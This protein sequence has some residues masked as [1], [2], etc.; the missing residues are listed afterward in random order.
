MNIKIK[1]LHLAYGSKVLIEEFNI[2]VSSGERVAIMG[3]NGAGKSTL[4]KYINKHYNCIY[5]PQFIDCDGSGGEKFMRSFN[6]AQKILRCEDSVALLLDEPTNHLDTRNRRHLFR[7]L[8]R[9]DG[10]LICISHDIELLEMFSNFWHIENESVHV[11]RGNYSDYIKERDK[12]SKKM[13]DDKEGLRKEKE[14]IS[15]LY[16]KIQERSQGSGAQRLVKEINLKRIL[17]KKRQV[18]DQINE[19]PDLQEVPLKFWLKPQ[20]IKHSMPIKIRDGKVTLSKKEILRNINLNIS[21]D[22]RVLIKGANG[23]GKTTLLKA[24]MNDP[25]VERTGDWKILSSDIGYFDQHYKNLDPEET[26]YNVIS[27]I[28]I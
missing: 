14:K 6:D 21:Y 10:T 9:Y 8:D 4:M 18:I 11:F 15:L 25:I 7:M 1:N 24:I 20:N 5:I 19:M 28:I 23:S 27:N 13:Q 3:K 22:D 12:I 16:K 17:D 2:S 26:V